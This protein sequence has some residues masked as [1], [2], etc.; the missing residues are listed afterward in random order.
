MLDYRPCASSDPKLV[1]PPGGFV[2]N[3]GLSLQDFFPGG[4]RA[5]PVAPCDFLYSETALFGLSAFGFLA[6]LLPLS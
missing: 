4:L 6:S 5:W 1:Q 2:A 3:G